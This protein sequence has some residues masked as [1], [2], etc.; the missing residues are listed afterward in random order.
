MRAAG[1]RQVLRGIE[2]YYLYGYFIRKKAR[3]G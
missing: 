3:G 1:E 2:E